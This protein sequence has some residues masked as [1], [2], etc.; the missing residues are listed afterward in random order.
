MAKIKWLKRAS[1]TLD[2]NVAYATMEY[3]KQTAR[4]WLKEVAHAESRIAMMPASFT[5]EPL[6][7]DK[8]HAYRYCH[9]M[10]RRFKIIFCYYPSSDIV[11]IVDIWDTKMN[12]DTLKQRM[13]K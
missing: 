3:G 10:N 4:R 8:K 6:L 2:R 9:L 11:R 5:R 1:E 12:P 7:F 13:Y